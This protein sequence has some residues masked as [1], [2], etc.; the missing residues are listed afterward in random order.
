VIYPGQVIVVSGS[1]RARS[2]AS[3]SRRSSSGSAARSGRVHVVRRGESLYSISRK[4]DLTVNQLKQ[5]NGLRGDA[6]RTGQRLV[7]KS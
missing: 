5:L 1:G 2:T 4:Y 3:T 7:V 6:I